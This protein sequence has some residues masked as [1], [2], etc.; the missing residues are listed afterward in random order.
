MKKWGKV[1]LWIG[2]VW[3]ILVLIGLIVLALNLKSMANSF[4]S[5]ETEMNPI[6]TNFLSIINPD[7]PFGSLFFYFIL[8]GIPSWVIFIVVGIWGREKK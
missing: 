8:F 6:I 1:L 7:S 2:I 4:A 5:S 3:I